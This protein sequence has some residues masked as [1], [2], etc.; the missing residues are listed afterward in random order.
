MT[1]ITKKQNDRKK[2]KKR[3][4]VDVFFCCFFFCFFGDSMALW[5]IEKGKGREF[6]ACVYV[7]SV[8]GVR[9][10]ACVRNVMSDRYFVGFF[11][12][13]VAHVLQKSQ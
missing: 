6:L 8:W 1:H 2:S 11:L 12:V 10:H 3:K 13:L 4:S 5:R 9:V 7:V